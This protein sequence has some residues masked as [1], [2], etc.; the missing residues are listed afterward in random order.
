MAGGK[1]DQRQDLNK[2]Q[3]HPPEDGWADHD[4]RHDLQHRRGQAQPGHQTQG[5]RE[6][7]GDARHDREIQK[8]HVRHIEPSSLSGPGASYRV[9][10]A[11]YISFPLASQFRERL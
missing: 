7:K 9:A 10:Y 1:T 2:F 8:R 3:L 6:A 5:Q 11:R 4:A